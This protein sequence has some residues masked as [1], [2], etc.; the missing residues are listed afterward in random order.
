[1][2]ITV[3]ILQI[4]LL[5]QVERFQD[6]LVTV[7]RLCLEVIKKLA[8]ARHEAEKSATGGK[9]FFVILHVLREM[10]DPLGHEGNLEVCTSGVTVTLL[11][12]SKVN[13]VI[14]CH[15][16]GNRDR[17]SRFIAAKPSFD[18]RGLSENWG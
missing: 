12:I 13:S 3:A 8:T 11:E 6:R 7:F 10:L 5:A 14:V 15:F 2:K 17:P 16:C 4:V 9:I 18:G 1:M